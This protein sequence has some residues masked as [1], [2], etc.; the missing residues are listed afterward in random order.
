[1]KNILS[2]DV[3][4]TA[5][6]CIVYDSDFKELF[7][8]NKEYNLNTKNEGIAE[9]DAEVYFNTFLNSINDIS[10]YGIN[11]TDIGSI[12][13]TTQGETLIPVD[14]NGNA[15]SPAI[16]WLDTRAADEAAYIKSRIDRQQMY[17]TT[18]LC[19]IDGALPAAKILWLSKNQSEIYNNTYKILL[20]EDYLIYRLTGK[21]VSEKSLQSS[22][23]W[24]D[25]V[26]DRI[27]EDMLKTCNIPAEKLPDILPCGTV[28]GTVHKEFGFAKDT[29]VVTG[30][31]DQISSAV[32]NVLY[33][34]PSGRNSFNIL[35][36]GLSTIPDFTLGAMVCDV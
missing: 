25:I 6:K 18:G 31:M 16:V 34:L 24:Y 19:D 14:K 23:G 3:G 29:V 9:L 12:V 20:L 26:N 8:S 28:V 33:S 27:Y 30:A 15:L 5:M 4:T 32:T 7:Y 10:E 2:F 21:F 1:M 11:L 13:F 36:A 22:T 35:L 17:S